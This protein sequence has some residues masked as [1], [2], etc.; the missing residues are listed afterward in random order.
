MVDRRGRPWPTAQREALRDGVE[1]AVAEGVAAQQAPGGEDGSPQRAEAL[2]RLDRVG[3]A[4]RLV[5]AAAGPA[6]G[7]PALVG[8]DQLPAGSVSRGTAS[9]STS[10]PA[11][12]RC[13]SRRRPCPRA[14]AARRAPG[15]RRGRSRSVSG[16]RSAMPQNASRRARLTRLRSTA[17]PILRLAET[18]S[19]TSRSSVVLAREG[20]EDQE[21]GRVR[22]AVAVDPVELA[23]AREAPATSLRRHL[24]GQALPAFAA[25]ALEDRPAAAG[26]HPCPESVGLRPLPLLRL[27]G[28][29]HSASQYTDAS[30]NFC[31]GFATGPESRRR[32]VAMVAR[33]CKKTPTDSSSTPSGRT[34][35]DASGPRSRT[36]PSTS[37]CGRCRCWARA[38]RPSTSPPP[39]ASAPGSS[40]AT[41][42]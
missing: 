1:A 16:S 18:P 29:L 13:W 11:P 9:R 39:T 10:P 8:A 41:R 26:A 4:G 33:G 20:V 32:R 25:A 6:R 35:S 5:A 30:E 28:A 42:A 3:R 27:V 34:C 14:R 22:G 2:D 21:A 12:L 40:G 24:D 38:G 36:R 17:P 15:G 23:A 37:G 7:D 31:S 19:L